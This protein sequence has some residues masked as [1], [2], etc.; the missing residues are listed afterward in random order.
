MATETVIEISYCVM[1]YSI[2]YNSQKKYSLQCFMTSLCDNIYYSHWAYVVHR[3]RPYSP[4][5]Y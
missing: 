5:L 1:E 3:W 2:V 4:K